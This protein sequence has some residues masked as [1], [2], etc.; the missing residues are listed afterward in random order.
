MTFDEWV[1]MG[2]EQGWCSAPVC[3]THD[4]VPMSDDEATEFDAGEDPCVW[5]LR[6][7]G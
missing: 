2:Q 3:Q 7:T 1:A 5:V 6:V 4:M